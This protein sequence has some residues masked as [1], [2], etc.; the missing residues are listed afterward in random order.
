MADDR[1]DASTGQAGSQVQDQAALE[2]T[3][4]R[5][6]AHYEIKISDGTIGAHDLRQIKTTPDDFGLMAYDPGLLNTAICHSEITLVDGERGILEYRGYP[7]EQLAERSSYSEVAYLLAYGE[8]PDREQLREF[9]QFIAGSYDV[10]TA[11]L[12]SVRE[13][14][15]DA[16]PMSVL[17]SMVSL[18]GTYDPGSRRPMSAQALRELMLRLIPRVA[19]MAAAAYRHN[20]GKPFVAPDPSL[21][22]AGN[23]LTM[24]FTEP[25]QKYTIDPAIE[26]A[27]D[28]LFI[29]HADH[30]Q[31]CSTN[32]LKNIAS[33]GADPYSAVSGALG[34]LSGPSHGAANEA[35]LNMLRQIGSV[36]RVPSFIADVKAGKGGR[37]MGFGH[38]VYKTYDPR[39]R[40]VKQSA[41]EVFAITGV[42]PRLEIALEL[43]RIGLTDEYFVRRRLY[44]NVDFYSGIIYEALGLPSEMFP[45]MFAIARTAGWVAHMLEFE[46]EPERKIVRPRQV[47]VGPARR[48]LPAS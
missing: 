22:L 3:D 11:V 28:V 29:M 24:F 10:P 4:S 43:E 39:A 31:N 14:P 13:L 12:E 15:R 46:Q 19:V 16:H 23:V 38:R 7:I 48:D 27:L 35:V 37:L 45:V 2:L 42:N 40:L 9:E 34:A 20:I 21:S 30:E 17:I 6:G 47:Y 18:L 5:T 32:V 8:L 26:R 33:A 1:S 41:D 44:P 36:D 25:G